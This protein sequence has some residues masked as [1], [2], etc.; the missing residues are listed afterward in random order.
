MLSGLTDLE[1]K[2]NRNSFGTEIYES[3]CTQRDKLVVSIK[4]S[5]GKLL[6]N[7][8]NIV[9]CRTIFYFAYLTYWIYIYSWRRWTRM[10]LVRCF[11]NNFNKYFNGARFRTHDLRGHY[12]P[13]FSCCAL[14]TSAMETKQYNLIF[15]CIERTSKSCLNLT[16]KKK[17]KKLIHFSFV[18]S[19]Y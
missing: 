16:F 5:G 2:L 12:E 8:V 11:L 6:M 19:A 13:I 7:T 15:K 3:D 9:S 18:Y 4:L 17:F 1:T 14:P 10:H